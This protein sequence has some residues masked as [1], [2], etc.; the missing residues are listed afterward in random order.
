MSD[1]IQSLPP[2]TLAFLQRHNLLRKLVRCEVVE[3]TIGTVQLE[4]GEL[5]QSRQRFKQRHGISNPD[6]EQA[7]Q[8]QNGLSDEAL[9]WQMTLPPR[10]SHYVREHFL[11][12]AESHFLERKNQLDQV[13]Y[14]LI[15]VGDPYLARELYLRIA[16]E[17]ASFADL[18]ASH[19]E[20]PE[21][22]ARGL[23]G[24]VPLTQAHPALAE[25]LRTTSKGILHEPFRLEKWWLILR[26]ESYRPARFDDAMA[27]R[28]ARELFEQ[29]VDSETNLR[30]TNLTA[31]SPVPTV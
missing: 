6:L 17:E 1:R 31:A 20:G 22:A 24:P 5:E 15:R 9:A 19:S 16:D 8:R 14:S 12:K 13:V 23:V 2:D 4:D 30:L 28:M 25:R 10:I 29:W 3:E 7:F 26:L 21:K 27:D 11:P 18:A